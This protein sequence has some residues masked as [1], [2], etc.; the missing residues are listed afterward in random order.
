MFEL[1]SWLW[2]AVL[3]VLFAVLLW[4]IFEGRV[5]P[6]VR[7]PLV[8]ALTPLATLIAVVAGITL[9]VALS[10]PY[11]PPPRVAKNT[12]PATRTTPALSEGPETTEEKTKEKTKRTGKP[13][14]TASPSPSPSPSPLPSASPSASPSP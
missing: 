12:E 6:L 8:V 4:Y 14:A 11:E 7:L 1:V 2:P 3:A 9:S 10:G 13:S 5:R